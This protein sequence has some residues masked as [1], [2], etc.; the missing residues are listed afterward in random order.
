MNS[1]IDIYQQHLSSCDRPSSIHLKISGPR[2]SFC[3]GEGEKFNR[4]SASKI[5]VGHFV[6]TAYMKEC[7]DRWNG[8]RWGNEYEK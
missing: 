7:Y 2:E 5:T 3:Y 6:N 8:L 4:R 1:S